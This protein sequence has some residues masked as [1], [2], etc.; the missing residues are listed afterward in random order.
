VFLSLVAPLSA[1]VYCIYKPH[2]FCIPIERYSNKDTSV[3]NSRMKVLVWC[4]PFLSLTSSFPTK[5]SQRLPSSNL[6]SSSSDENNDS[7]TSFSSSRSAEY[8]SRNGGGGR[9]REVLSVIS[10][11]VAWAVP[12]I[13]QAGL[14]DD[15]GTDPSKIVQTAAKPAPAAAAAPVKTTGPG[16]IDPTHKGCT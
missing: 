6:P 2:S 14:L 11:A 7:N 16:G 3:H 4:L 12:A 15:F 5:P 9:R 13:A 8:H 10:G 1:E